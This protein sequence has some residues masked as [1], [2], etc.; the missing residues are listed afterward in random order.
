M[1]RK[2]RMTPNVTTCRRHFLVLSSFTTYHRVCNSINTTGAT[3]GA[4]TAYP[5]GASTFIPGFY[6][7]SCYSIFSFMCMFFRSLL[8]LLSFF[9]W[10]LCCLISFDIRI[11]ITPLVSSNSSST[12]NG[13]DLRCSGRV[14]SSCS[15]SGTSRI[16]LVT[17]LVISQE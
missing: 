1:L 3:S 12:K 9:F 6:W 7:G 13:G 10:P 4:G 14:D 15:T 17:D 16:N 2:P 8:I 11:L 5:S